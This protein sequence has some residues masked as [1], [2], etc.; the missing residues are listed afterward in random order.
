MRDLPPPD[1]EVLQDREGA[2]G[3]VIAGIHMRSGADARLLKQ[4]LSEAL[5][6]R[7]LADSAD[8]I[9]RWISEVDSAQRRASEDL[10][11]GWESL[12]GSPDILRINR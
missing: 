6:T 2:F 12:H 8:R 4:I 1:V 9:R 10:W 3:A 5:A 11:I 7:T